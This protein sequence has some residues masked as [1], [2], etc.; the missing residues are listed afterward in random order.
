MVSMDRYLLEFR[1]GHYP[2]GNWYV[3]AFIDGEP[4]VT[5]GPFEDKATAEAARQAWAAEV[6]V[7]AKEHGEPML[8]VG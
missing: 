5:R 7:K 1:V 6:K 3:G 8:P 4:R 2:N